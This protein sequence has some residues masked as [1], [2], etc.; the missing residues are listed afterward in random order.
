MPH[1]SGTRCELPL[2]QRSSTKRK[3][4]TLSHP[5]C[6]TMR[7]FH[8]A[9][10]GHAG[11]IDIELLIAPGLLQIAIGD[12]VAGAQRFGAMVADLHAAVAVRTAGRKS[13]RVI[14]C[15]MRRSR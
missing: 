14:A 9:V 1:H 2:R 10:L 5:G 7:L 6:S 4:R 11:A 15:A 8:L 12:R 13:L 3:A